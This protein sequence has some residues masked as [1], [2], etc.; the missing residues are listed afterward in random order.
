LIDKLIGTANCLVMSLAH[1]EVQSTANMID[2]MRRAHRLNRQRVFVTDLSASGAIA[3]AIL[4]TY[5]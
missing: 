3:A 1:G 5:P 2:A 4:A